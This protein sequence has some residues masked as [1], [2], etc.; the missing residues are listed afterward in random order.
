MSSI[1]TEVADTISNLLQ[2]PNVRNAQNC[3]TMLLLG[4]AVSREQKN[5]HIFEAEWAWASM[6]KMVSMPTY[7]PMIVV[8]FFGTAR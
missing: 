4:L 2:N 6:P 3:I 1:D 8:C 7:T 5:T